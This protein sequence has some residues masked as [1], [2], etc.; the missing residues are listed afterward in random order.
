MISLP[1]SDTD[2]MLDTLRGR[3][4]GRVSGRMERGRKRGRVGEKEGEVH[5]GWREGGREGRREKGRKGEWV[6]GR[7]RKKGGN[8]GATNNG[9]I[10]TRPLPVSGHC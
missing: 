8:D 9:D 6:R 10:G 3:E 7:E 2:H 1:A 4:S 5:V